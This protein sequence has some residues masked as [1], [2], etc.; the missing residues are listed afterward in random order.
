VI[1]KELNKLKVS[2]DEDI[3]FEKIMGIKVNM[4]EFEETIEISSVYLQ[5]EKIFNML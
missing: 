4:D 3:L 2:V 5:K 1:E